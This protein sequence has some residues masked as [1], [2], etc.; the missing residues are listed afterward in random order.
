MP[1]CASIPLCPYW[2]GYSKGR[3]YL[4]I[5]IEDPRAVPCNEPTLS[6][7][8]LS[9]VKVGCEADTGCFESSGLLSYNEIVPCI[10]PPIRRQY[11]RRT[12]S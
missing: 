10:I 3:G 4:A 2:K 12:R 8:Q 1:V 7:D 9:L 6:T 11:P 5:S